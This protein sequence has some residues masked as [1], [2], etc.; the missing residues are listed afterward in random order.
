MKINELKRLIRHEILNEIFFDNKFNVNA[1]KIAKKIQKDY[2]AKLRYV[3]PEKLDKV[4]TDAIQG[5]IKVE[6][7]D[8]NKHDELDHIKSEVFDE[9]RL[10][11]ALTD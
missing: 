10:L 4:I 8:D 7:D 6:F 9:L 2:G 1:S 5:N 11:G 3:S